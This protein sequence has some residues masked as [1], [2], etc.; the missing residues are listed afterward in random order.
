M[1]KEINLTAIVAMDRNRGIGK[2]HDIPWP[3]KLRDDMAH[4]K[5]YTMR[6]I[7]VQGRRTFQSIPEKYRPLPGRENIILSR[8]PTYDAPGCAVISDPNA[9]VRISESREVCIIGGAEIYKLFLPVVTRIIVTHV[10][11]EVIGTDTFFPEILPE[12]KRN[13]MYRF[14]ADRRNQFPFSIYNYERPHH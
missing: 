8:N 13:L 2:N 12:W 5:N 14:K 4:F 3:G 10:D 6:K 1:H 7:V 11:T 9:I